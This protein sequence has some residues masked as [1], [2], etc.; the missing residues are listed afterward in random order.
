[1]KTDWSIAD[2]VPCRLRVYCWR[3]LRFEVM[4]LASRWSWSAACRVCSREMTRSRSPG[5]RLS[6]LADSGGGGGGGGLGGGWSCMPNGL[7]HGS[8]HSS[9]K[10]WTGRD[11]RPVES[12][13]EGG[14]SW[15]RGRKQHQTAP[16]GREEPRWAQDLAEA[17]EANP[18]RLWQAVPAGRD[19]CWAGSLAAEEP[20][21]VSG[22]GD[23]QYGGW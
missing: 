15:L 7:P 19:P 21:E 23:Q 8:V 6:S 1:M 3:T 2:A 11:N 13:S 16:H 12:R 17:G 5:A 20:V 9:D 22:S 18:D 4:R 14:E 10:M